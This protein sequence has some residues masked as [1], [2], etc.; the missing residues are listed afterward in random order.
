MPTTRLTY[1]TGAPLIHVIWKIWK[2]KS[3][4]F[5]SLKKWCCGQSV[6][7]T[8]AKKI[9]NTIVWHSN[10]WM[11]HVMLS[12]TGRTFFLNS[13]CSGECRHTTLPWQI[14]KFHLS[15]FSGFTI[16]LLFNQICRAF[17]SM[18]VWVC[19]YVCMY[20]YTLTQ[21]HSSIWSQTNL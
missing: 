8:T 21:Q 15:C 18:Y 6:S 16:L 17:Q 20:I 3:T 19:M 9:H 14:L 10:F 11:Q 5:P 4:Y 1:L 7:Y 12:Q 13:E 2:G